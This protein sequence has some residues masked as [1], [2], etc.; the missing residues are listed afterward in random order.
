MLQTSQP[1]CGSCSQT[2]IAPHRWVRLRAATSSRSTPGAPTHPESLAW[3]NA[4]WRRCSMPEARLL[5]R[6][7]RLP[8]LDLVWSPERMTAFLNEP[9]P[10]HLFPAA[11]TAVT[12][13]NL[14]YRPARVCIALYELTLAG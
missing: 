4:S 9:G 1:S 2:P 10:G 11:V 6:D 14:T 3:P 5:Q 13:T 7:E 12:L 8:H